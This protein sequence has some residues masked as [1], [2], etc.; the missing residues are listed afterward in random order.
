[1]AKIIDNQSG[2]YR[3]ISD[4]VFI[5][6]LLKAKSE[7]TIWQVLKM[8]NKWYEK[9]YSA[10][11][12]SYTGMTWHDYIKNN[13]IRQKEMRSK[14]GSSKD[15]TWRF[16]LSIPQRIIYIYKKLYPEIFSLTGEDSRRFYNEFANKFPE[17]K[18]PE[19]V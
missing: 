18:V 10:T 17:F 2:R 12:D 11:I 5:D 8:I 3:E 14:T 9:R 16:L 1:M 7:K 13:K 19:K 6:S 15:K 4:M